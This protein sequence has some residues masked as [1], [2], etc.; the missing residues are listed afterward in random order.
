VP[1]V[2]AAESVTVAVA[3]AVLLLV[4]LLVA[5]VASV[6]LSRPTV[7]GKYVRCTSLDCCS[8]NKEMHNT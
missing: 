1:A 6:V 4:V 5:V 3:A 2:I 7:I 8:K